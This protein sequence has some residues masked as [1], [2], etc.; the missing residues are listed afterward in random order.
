MNNEILKELSELRNKKKKTIPR[1]WREGTH[2]PPRA[3]PE[4][5]AVLGEF[6]DEPIRPLA[7][8]P[9]GPD[10]PVEPTCYGS[11]AKTYVKRE[12][13]LVQPMSSCEK[14]AQRLEAEDD[15]DD[16]EEDQ[17]DGDMVGV[18]TTK[19]SY[20]CE[21]IRIFQKVNCANKR[22]KQFNYFGRG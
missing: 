6:Q 14:L 7:L 20:Y 12:V 22:P 18:Q 19:K 17:N 5:M 8:M 1:L 9:P 16:I 13:M 21:E 4:A 10:T 3:S 11:P 15:S 2:P